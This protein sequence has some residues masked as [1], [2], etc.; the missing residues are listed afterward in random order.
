MQLG[1]D[2]RTGSEYQQAI[3]F[4]TVAQ[5][6]HEQAH[7]LVLAAG[8]VAHHGAGAVIDLGLFTGRG[9]DH[10]AGWRGVLAAEFAHETPHALV[11]AGKTAA[12]HQILPDGLSVAPAG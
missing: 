7:A 5:S 4:T 2:L 12:I 8:R 10:R 6:Q 3:R 9:F 1:P 11:R